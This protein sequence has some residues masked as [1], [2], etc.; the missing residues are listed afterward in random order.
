MLHGSETWLLKTEDMRR[1]STFECRCLLGI[2][3]IWWENLVINSEVRHQVPGPTIQSPEEGM[4]DNR[5]RWLEYVHR[6]TAS[7]HAIVQ[8]R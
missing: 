4:N 1:L 7:P 2:D 5:I 8:S 3:R 6:I